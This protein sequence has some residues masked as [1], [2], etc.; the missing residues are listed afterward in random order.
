MLR[1]HDIVIEMIKPPFLSE[2][3]IARFCWGGGWQGC[4]LSELGSCV[5]GQPR[6]DKACAAGDDSDGQIG[7]L[8]GGGSNYGLSTSP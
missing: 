8:E 5:R 7:R 1:N 2:F 6:E 4:A 3:L